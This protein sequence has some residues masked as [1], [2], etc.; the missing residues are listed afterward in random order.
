[1]LGCL[2]ATL[3]SV[4][5]CSP[6]TL[7]LRLEEDHVSEDGSLKEDRWCVPAVVL[8]RLSTESFGHQD[9]LQH[10]GE[11]LSMCV[12]ELEA[13]QGKI[14]ASDGTVTFFLLR[15]SLLPAFYLLQRRGHLSFASQSQD[16]A[17]R[18]TASPTA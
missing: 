7:Q 6:Q 2:V 11:C 1:M 10:F 5:P 15:T 3:C 16:G 4:L 17:F 9:P 8:L 14:G 12:A 18:L 13:L